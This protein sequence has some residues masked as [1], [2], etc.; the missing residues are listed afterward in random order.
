MKN[1]VVV[2]NRRQTLQS[3]I[4]RALFEVLKLVRAAQIVPEASAAERI[5]DVIAAL[6]YI[7]A[8]QKKD[9]E[10]V[11]VLTMRY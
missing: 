4:N 10:V 7:I 9:V 8:K 3:R 5:K 6:G 11:S 1:V 2:V